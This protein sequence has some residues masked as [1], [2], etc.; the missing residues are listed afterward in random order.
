MRVPYAME[1]N[2]SLP[3]NA[4]LTPINAAI[5]T[6]ARSSYAT[7]RDVCAPGFLGRWHPAPGAVA[8]TP[9]RC[10]PVPAQASRQ[11]AGA[12]DPR[13]LLSP[14]AADVLRDQ[15]LARLLQP[16]LYGPRPASRRGCA[17]RRHAGPCP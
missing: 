6:R 13:P 1:F 7:G 8:L 2:R 17:G 15:R 5:F 3:L 9:D 11:R 10:G 14:E 12:A 4:A 16:E